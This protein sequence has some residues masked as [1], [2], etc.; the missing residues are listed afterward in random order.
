[1]PDKHHIK[2]GCVVSGF[3]SRRILSRQGAW[4]PTRREAEEA[5]GVVG[6]TQECVPTVCQPTGR[7]VIELINPILRGWVNYFAVGIRAG[8]FRLLETR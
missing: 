5:N 3:E 6:E 8:A 2:S 1:M 4:R 7:Q